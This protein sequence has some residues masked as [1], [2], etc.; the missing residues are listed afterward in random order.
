MATNETNVMTSHNLL[1]YSGLLFNKGNTRTPFSTLIGGKSRT[2]N[3]WSFPT[4]LSYTTGGGVSQ[5]A[6]TESASLTAPD[7]T[8]VTRTQ[9]TNVCQI[10]QKS[11]AISYGKKSSMGQLSGLN[12]AGQEANPANELDFQVANTMAEIANDIEYSF[13]NG[14]YQDG[15]YDDVAYK[16]RGISNAITTNIKAASGAGLGFWLL[17]ELIQLIGDSNAPTDNLVLMAKPVNIMQLNADASSNGLTVVPAAREINGIKIDQIITPFGSVGVMANSRLKAGEA[18]IANPGVCAP[19]YMPVP[20]KGNFFLEDLAK[21]GAADK[22]Q[23]YGQVG[24]DYGAEFYHGKLTGLAGS[25]TAP[26]YSRK[27]YVSGGVVAT[28]ETDAVVQGATLNKSTVAADDTATVAVSSIQY[29]IKP[30]TDASIAYLWQVRA[31]TGTIWTDLTDSY[32]GYNTSELTV[33][34]ADAEKHYRCKITATGSATGTAYSD[35]C[36]VNA[37]G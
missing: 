3:H 24:L 35:E 2:V 27:V 11:L 6:I 4:S 33:K 14:E 36:T 13:L 34:A 37:A 21:T 20:G 30:A 32:T 16:T 29:N 31:K 7:P 15:D 23:I 8:F 10:F 5:P 28:T 1:N 26:E 25:F 18:I 22:Y 19:V 17:A 12:I 9:A